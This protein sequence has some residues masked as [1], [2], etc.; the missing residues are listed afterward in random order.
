MWVLDARRD[1][2]KVWFPVVW[3]IKKDPSDVVDYDIH[4][5]ITIDT[6]SVFNRNNDTTT[7]MANVIPW[8]NAPKLIA[9]TSIYGIKA[10]PSTVIIEWVSSDHPLWNF[11]YV[12]TVWNYWSATNQLTIPEKWTYSIDFTCWDSQIWYTPDTWNYDDYNILVNWTVVATVNTPERLK[13]NVK[14]A[15]EL[16]KWDIITFDYAFNG[17]TS[18]KQRYFEATVIKLW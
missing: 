1:A 15:S 10:D 16:R 4:E 18:Y 2:E 12:S 7:W 17:G 6:S 8:I 13:W 3:E 5:E 14:Y 9:D 11:N